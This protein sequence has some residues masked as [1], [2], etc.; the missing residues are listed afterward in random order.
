MQ[1]FEKENEEKALKKQKIKDELIKGN[2]DLIN[3]KKEK[4]D[5]LLKE[6]MKYKEFYEKEKIEYKNDLLN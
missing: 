5:K 4:K 6:D 1:K 2:L 3:A